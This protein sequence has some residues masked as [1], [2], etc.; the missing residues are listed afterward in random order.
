MGK[1]IL[2]ISL[3]FGLISP[4][5]AHPVHIAVLNMDIAENSINLRLSTFIDDWELAYY[6]YFGKTIDLKEENL[7]E[8]E[9]FNQY[10]DAS[11]QLGL[12]KESNIIALQLDSISFQDMSMIVEMHYVLKE[13]PKTLYIY[14]SILADIYDDQTNLLIFSLDGKEKGIKF[15]YKKRH[16][17]VLL[18]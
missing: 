7:Y 15:D 18:K 16:D 8:F 1:F 3:L 13:K 6:H 12:N 5:A 2:Y 14:N 11:F 17:I 10:L 4:A 9:W